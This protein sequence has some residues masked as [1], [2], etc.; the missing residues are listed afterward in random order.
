MKINT[1]LVSIY[2]EVG[3]TR[4]KYKRIKAGEIKLLTG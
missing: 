2:W 4:L 1:E 3:N